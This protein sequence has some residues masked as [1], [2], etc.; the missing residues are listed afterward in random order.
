M[1]HTAI[2]GFDFVQLSISLRLWWYL[3]LVPAVALPFGWYIV[4]LWYAGFWDGEKTAMRRRQR[5]WLIVTLVLL[6]MGL[7]AVI[8]YANPVPTI[9]STL[10]IKF[11]VRSVGGTSILVLGYAAYLITCIG[12]SLDALIRPGPS[13]RVM[14]ELARQRARGWLIVASFFL[15]LVSLLVISVLSWALWSV[16]VEGVYIITDQVL[17]IL[18]QLDLLIS[19][20]LA[21]TAVVLG[22][23]VVAYEIFTGKTLPRRGLRRQWN[24]AIILAAGYGFLVGGEVA[25]ELQPVYTILLTTILMTLFFAL[26]SWRSYAERE[27]YISHLRPF[28]ASQG[29]YEQLLTQSPT[30]MPEIEAATPFQALCNDVLGVK[31]AYLVP[32]GPLAPLVG[33]PLTY[34]DKTAVSLPP[35]TELSAHFQSPATFSRALNPDDYQGAAWAVPLVGRAGTHW[36]AAIRG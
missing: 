20:I 29:L 36:P 7:T 35:M 32:L 30:A 14:G 27:R 22:Q 5:R 25:L 24:R 11:A 10:S 19:V 12:L 16:R 23:A 34:P 4:T 15:L 2:L 31:L 21:V 26:I 33:E 9:F 17:L 6:G 28:V 1:T 18:T 8:I 13:N 3:G